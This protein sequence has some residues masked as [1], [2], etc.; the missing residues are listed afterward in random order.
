[1]IVHNLIYTRIVNNIATES[2]LDDIINVDDLPY[3][4]TCT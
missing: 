4:N 3:L 2:I 1:M